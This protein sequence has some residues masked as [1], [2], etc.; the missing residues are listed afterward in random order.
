MYATVDRLR[1]FVSSTIS[2]CAAE[3]ERIR[4]AIRSLNHEPILFEDVGARPHPPRE[5]YRTRLE[6]SHVFVGVYREC[7]GWIAPDMRISGIE[8]EFEIATSRSMDRL[9][10][11]YETPGARESRLQELIDRAQN[12]GITT[13]SYSSP[14][15]LEQLVRRDVTA[16]VS[17]GFAQQAMVLRE[18]PTA[19]DVLE[20]ILP[21]KEHRFRRRVVEKAIT[22]RLQESR[23]VAIVGPLGSGKTVLLTQLA[24]GHDWVFVDGTDLSRLDLLASV[25]NAIRKRL[26]RPAM[27]VTTEDQA[28]QLYV[29]TTRALEPTTIAVDG[30]DEANAL[31]KLPM[32]RHRLLFTSR[33]QLDWLPVDRYDLPRLTH[34]EVSSWMSQLRAGGV[35]RYDMERIISLSEANPLYLRFYAVGGAPDEDLALRDLEI[36]AVQSLGPHEREIV[37]YAALSAHPLSLGDLSAMM[38]AQGGP[39]AVAEHVANAGGLLMRGARGIQLIHEHL[40]A[41]VL[42]R[43]RELPDRWSFFTVRLGD[44]LERRGHFLSA[45][46]LYLDV[47]DLARADGILPRATNQAVLFG[48]GGIAVRVFCRQAA[49]A[50]RMRRYTDE[51]HALL[52]LS[53]A[54]AQGGETAEAAAALERAQAT[55]DEGSQV[56][57]LRVREV[58]I[59]VGMSDRPRGIRIEALEGLVVEYE[60]LGESFHAARA[61]TLLGKEYIDEKRFEDAAVVSRAAHQVLQDLGDEYGV[62]V[63]SI[64]LAA[65]LSGVPG[66]ADE[67]LSIVQKVQKGWDQE[68]HPRLRAVVCNILTRHYRESGELDIAAEHALEAISI[69]ETLSEHRVVSVN[70]TNLGNVYR[71]GR[72]LEK[73]IEQYEL[74]EKAAVQGSNAEG[75]AW[76]NE[77]LASV[78]NEKG[79][80]GLAE[81]R[82]R[83]ACALGSRI[84]HQTLIARAEEERAVALAG[85]GDLKAAIEAYGA[86]CRAATVPGGSR[87]FFVSLL[88]DGLALVSKRGRT[89]LKVRLVDLAVV[90]GGSSDR[91]TGDEGEIG[92]LYEGLVK[93]TGMGMGNVVVPVVSL[94]MRDVFAGRPGVLVRRMVR[95]AIKELIDRDDGNIS[96]S[97]IGAIA[98]V[99]MTQSGEE[100]GL[101]DVGHVAEMVVMATDRIYYKPQLDGAG[102]WTVRLEMGEGV[103]ITVA[104]LDDSVRTS[105]ITMNLVLLLASCDEMIWKDV[106]GRS[107]AGEREVVVNVCFKGELDAQFG[108]ETLGLRV[109]K[110]GFGV[111]EVRSE[112][113][114]GQIIAIWEGAFGRAWQPMEEGISDIHKLFGGLICSL[115]ARWLSEEVEQDV[116]TP[117]IVRLVRSIGYARG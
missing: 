33:S 47:E 17:S 4:T 95:Q 97:T 71:D 117:K 35:T 107:G 5:V 46:H 64:N 89:D 84:E 103:V 82:A 100:W 79:E 54:L 73:A 115:A 36:R 96:R 12:A 3:R 22:E 49:L 45:F 15:E 104:Q 11:I 113:R 111:M 61:R 78:M 16:V 90:R 62:G 93:L 94:I 108:A 25:A 80:Y 34:D 6:E 106:L 99:L 105:L 114:T 87:A 23:R 20:A 9:V 51:V 37:T 67:A 32:D 74:A 30:A 68:E 7:Y 70:R 86:A 69:G 31:C 81:H 101:G 19:H 8:D 13:A 29:D 59:F 40:R 10:Y 21:K 27:T 26:D 24:L 1:I 76:A 42:D 43:L 102:H 83:Y 75:E 112:E 109:L 57:R 92:I 85:Q 110:D 41:T 14:E 72:N 55:A 28:V 38:E 44:H 39:E 60:N 52:N 91:V 116:L 65:A 58:E 18:A 50:R 53:Y 48:G 56:L 98:A 88:C 77:L 66:K 2:E 63:A